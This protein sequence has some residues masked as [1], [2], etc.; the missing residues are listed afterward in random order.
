MA[1]LIDFS[2]VN[3]ENVLSFSAIPCPMP[4]RSWYALIKER[5]G[6]CEYFTH[7][8]KIND[9]MYLAYRPLILAAKNIIPDTK[10]ITRSVDTAEKLAQV[11]AACSNTSKVQA[12]IST[13]G[14][15]EFEE[16]NSFFVN[17]FRSAKNEKVTDV[18][19]C[20]R[21]T[22]AR[23]LFRELGE[24]VKKESF[25]PASVS[26]FISSMYNAGADDNSRSNPTF[27]SKSRCFCT[28]SF[29]EL[30]L[31]IRWQ[32]VPTSDEFDFD[33]VLRLIP[34]SIESA[35]TTF[36]QL[37]YLPSQID[38]LDTISRTPQGGTFIAGI[39]GSGKS[40][41]LRTM[42]GL[43]K[44]NGSKKIYTVEDPVEYKIY[45]ATQIQVQRNDSSGNPYA[46]IMKMLMRADPDIIMPGEIRDADTSKCAVDIIR[47]GQGLYSTVHAGSGIGIAGRLIDMGIE[48][49][50]FGEP[51]FLS[52]LIYQHLLPTICP[53]CRVSIN[54]FDP[55][56]VS[57]L[58]PAKMNEAKE[59]DAEM[60]RR[61]LHKRM[62]D[63][64]VRLKIP[65]EQVFVRD[66]RGCP[67]C[68]SGKSGMTVAA[69]VILPDDILCELLGKGQIREA[70][71]YYR[72][73][74]G[75]NDF[76]NPD[77]TGKTAFEAGLYKVSVGQIDPFDLQS[78]FGAKTM[79][80]LT[81]ALPNWKS[82][83]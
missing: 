24:M 29:K 42:M 39:T 34:D 13:A 54:I 53:K 10:Q 57:H 30:Q 21:K 60:R 56:D 36:E 41:T 17:L 22:S 47:S 83:P 68:R 6:I 23:I 18:H 80:T 4:M 51:G 3:A 61:L 40:T 67:S 81:L 50:V 46:D 11:Y 73:L 1:K 70:L 43:A 38:L 14:N 16:S 37:G 5:N 31:R 55:I 58:N 48:R 71:N 26:G 49:Q 76:C 66:R 25:E 44:D 35:D 12:A 45:G 64:M 9:K 33:I 52:G 59:I 2:Q 15:K 63:N 28:L 82:T 69:E 79:E 65:L 7:S 62:R 32:T 27:S 20:V 78:L 75:D 19:I 77:C 74:R 8:S 72:S